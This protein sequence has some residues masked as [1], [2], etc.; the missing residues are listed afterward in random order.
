MKAHIIGVEGKTEMALT[1]DTSSIARLNSALDVTSLRANAATT[2][3]NSG[4][5]LMQSKNYKQAAAAFRLASSYDPTN[6]DAYNFMAQ[7]FQSAGDDKSAINAYK[8]SI[9]IYAG[10][11]STGTS[12]TTQDQ[13][14]V[15]L[16]NLYIKDNRPADAIKQLQAATKVNPRNV[17]APYTLGQYLVQ[18]NRPQEAEPYLRTAVR[19]SPTDGNA[20]YGLALSL[21]KQGKTSDAIQAL[22][23]AVSLKK[24][25]TSAIYELGNAY[26]KNAQNDKVQ[27]QIDT[28]TKLN[29]SQSNSYAALLKVAIKQPKF[30]TVDQ[31]KSTFSPSLGAVPLVALDSNLVQPDASKEVSVTFLFDSSMDPT[32]VNNISN[33]SISKAR[34]ATINP[35][36]GLYDAGAYRSTDTVVSPIPTRVSYDSSTQEATM[37]FTLRQNSSATGTIDTSG[38]IFSFNGKDANGKQMDPKGDQISGNSK[39]AF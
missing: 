22:T 18:Q 21:E 33:W 30:V 31:T 4:I 2:S 14:Q 17:I 19:L 8:L 20:Y 6:T 29:T 25:F 26:A 9:Q 34:G 7:A 23:K 24:D 13:V 16:A 11:Q 5:T 36:T 27:T 28:L 15:N 3:L 37:F 1:L 39:T 10:G 32:S 12:G 38:I 35:S